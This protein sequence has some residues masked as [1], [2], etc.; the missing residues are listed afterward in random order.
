MKEGWEDEGA[1]RSSCTGARARTD[2]R[3]GRRAIRA[4]VRGGGFFPGFLIRLQFVR[5]VISYADPS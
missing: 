5:Y 4:L 2:E 1:V 3:G